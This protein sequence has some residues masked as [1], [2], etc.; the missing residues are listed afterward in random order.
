[1]TGDET[2]FQTVMLTENATEQIRFV[3]MNNLA[4]KFTVR[5]RQAR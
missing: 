1:V 5:V 3:S 2:P 4:K